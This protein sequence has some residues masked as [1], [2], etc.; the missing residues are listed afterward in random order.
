VRWIEIFL[1]PEQSE[2]RARLARLQGTYPRFPVQADPLTDVEIANAFRR[3]QIGLQTIAAQPAAGEEL[4]KA[5]TELRRSLTLLEGS[6]LATPPELRKLE[7]ASFGRL[8]VLLDRIDRLA[9]LDPLTIEKLDPAILRRFV[10][11]DG[12]W[13]IEVQ[14]RDPV[15]LDGFVTAMRGLVP[16]IAGKALIEA[17]TVRLLRDGMPWLLFGWLAAIL[18]VPVATFQDGR[19]IARVAV[20]VTTMALLALGGLALARSPLYPESLV[21]LAFMLALGSGAAMAGEAWRP[22]PPEAGIRALDSST[23]AILVAILLALAG[24]GTLVLSHSPAAR[25]FGEL[26]FLAVLAVA[27]GQF[28]ILPQLRGWT[29]ER[30]KPRSKTELP[31]R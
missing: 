2:K 11:K 28:L 17:D 13:R 19:S 12:R 23:R 31:A 30:I 26:V 9:R 1:P 22:L 29:G 8:Q 18:L 10:A 6:G 25:R 14:P 24:F 3:L 20:P 5:A 15:N 27:I 21:V 16:A 7:R 4:V